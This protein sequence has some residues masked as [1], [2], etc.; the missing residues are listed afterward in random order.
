MYIVRNDL[1]YRSSIT[2][3]AFPKLRNNNKQDNQ[4]ISTLREG[5]ISVK[6]LFI[7]LLITSCY[8][9]FHPRPDRP[10]YISHTLIKVAYSE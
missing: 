10:M 6:H 5:S 9:R 2:A 4:H 8:P 7:N 1:L 3:P